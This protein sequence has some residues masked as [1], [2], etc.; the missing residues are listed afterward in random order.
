MEDA[1]VLQYEGIHCKLTI[2]RPSAGV[3][4]VRISGHDLGEFG[5]VALRELEKEIAAHQRIELFIDAR[6]AQ[7]ASIDVSSA[8]ALWLA[9]NRSAFKGITMLTGSR[10]VRLTADFVQRFAE[11]GNLMDISTDPATFDTSLAA[12]CQGRAQ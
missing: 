4:V 6:D 1:K 5:D 7:S 8:W 12:A 11:L 3:A 9:K 10:F 2:E